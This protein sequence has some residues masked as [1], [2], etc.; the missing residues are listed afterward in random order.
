MELAIVRT[1]DVY[2]D[3]SNPRQDFGDIDALAE[4]FDLNPERPGEPFTPPLLVRDGGIYRIVDGERRYRALVKRKAETFTANV[5][6]SLD[7]ADVVMAMLATDDKLKLTE[8]ERSRGAQRMLLLGVD[9]AKVDKT[10]RKKGAAKVKRA[11]SIVDDA[12]L[13]M[14]FDRLLAIDEFADDPEAVEVL[15]NCTEDSWRWKVEGLKRKRKNAEL[16]AELEAEVARLAEDGYIVLFEDEAAAEEA[17]YA[18]AWISVPSVGTL[19]SMRA[20]YPDYAY[21]WMQGYEGKVLRMFKKKDGGDEVDPAEMEEA[22]RL[23]EICTDVL[24]DADA[25]YGG[26]VAAGD[27]AKCG[28]VSEMC[29]DAF[30]QEVMV[31]YDNEWKSIDND[32]SP[33]RDACEMALSAADY[34]LGWL[35]WAPG[36]ELTARQFLEMKKD[37]ANHRTRDNALYMLDFLEVLA[38]SGYPGNKDAMEIMGVLEDYRDGGEKDE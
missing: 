17:G 9:P 3:E 36:G 1:E 2:P 23:S 32:D 35:A 5:C 7:E 13:D 37:G 21:T 27:A 38:E 14:S 30:R 25:W 19:N 6:D 8:L 11:M 12:A 20:Q 22:A 24:A 28:R 33:F 29:A 31:D 34:A 4:S 10:V 26:I 15:T 18:N 16:I